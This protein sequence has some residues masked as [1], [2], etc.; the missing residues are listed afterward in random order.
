[1]L[2]GCRRAGRTSGTVREDIS[3]NDR[4]CA[5]AYRPC[6]AAAVAAARAAS[7]PG[8]GPSLDRNIS[9]A[10]D[11]LPL[12]IVAAHVGVELRLAHVHHLDA[13]RLV[14]LAHCRYR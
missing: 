14:T 13:H 9:V 3:R 6:P 4:R 1:M 5:R 2:P 7:G 11:L 8:R 10:R 12:A